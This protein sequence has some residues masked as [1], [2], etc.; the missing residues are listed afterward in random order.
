MTD[1]VTKRGRK[2]I[3]EKR[4]LL[5]QALR[6]IRAGGAVEGKATATYFLTRRLADA[7]LVEFVTVKGEGRG[8]P[9]KVA[10]VTREGEM[11]LATA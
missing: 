4:D 5:V 8:R 3:F 6:E 1:T 11:T 10:R 2:E 9:R 7:G